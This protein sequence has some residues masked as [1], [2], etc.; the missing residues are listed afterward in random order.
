[1]TT[2]FYRINNINRGEFL[3]VFFGLILLAFFVMILFVNNQPTCK[4]KMPL[5]TY[6]VSLSS[7]T[8][9]FPDTC[10]EIQLIFVK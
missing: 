6:E 1:M 4:I 8:E 9:S 5:P 3:I 7:L 2:I 10:Q